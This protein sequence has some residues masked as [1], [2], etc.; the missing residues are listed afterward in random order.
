LTAAG[1]RIPALKRPQD[2]PR[3]DNIEL[4]LVDPDSNVRDSLRSV[5]HHNGFRRVSTGAFWTDIRQRLESAPPDLLI[6][7]VDLADGD[8]CGAI[9]ALRHQDLGG[10]PFLPIIA[11]SRE[12]TPA[13][14]KRVIDSGADVLLGKPVSAEQL[15][16]RIRI[17]V[18][19]RKPFVVTSDYI[20][21]DRRK[22]ADR[23]SNVPLVEVPNALRM[24]LAGGRLPS[25][26]H[27][28][29]NKAAQQLNL[30]KLERLGFQIGY[31]IERI[32]P[33]LESGAWPDTRAVEFL[34]HLTGVAEEAARRCNGT[35]VDHVADLCRSMVKVAR[36]ILAATG[37][38]VPRDVRLLQPLSEAIRRGLAEMGDAA[39]IARRISAEI[40]K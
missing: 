29:V 19:N 36:A 35:P 30:M 5:L 26:M 28:T 22:S 2:A 1:N 15:T 37:A 21:P 14:V 4:L 9:R 10:D 24:R 6:S 34:E 27:Q 20:G 39:D 25:N 13:M 38:P 23:A 12:P 3:F 18:E 17:L 32:V 33:A 8:V 7:E 11:L 31:L 16:S 40:N